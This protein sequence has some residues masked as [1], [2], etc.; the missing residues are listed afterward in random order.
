MD[1]VLAIAFCI[2]MEGLFTGAE[3][4][5]ISADRHKLTERARSGKR[6]ARI[7]LDLLSRPDRTLATTLTGTDLFVVLS[8]VLT[9]S[10]LLPRVGAHAE[11]TTVAIISPL[12]ILFG[13]IVPKTFARPRADVLAEGAAR[14]VRA[15]QIFLYPLV[16]VVSFFGRL[17]SKPLG[18]VPPL[19][20]VVSREELRLILQM[21]RAGSDVEAHERVMVR[22]A[23]SF[24]EKKVADIFRPLAQVVALPEGA[25]C[26]EAAL[27]ASR[28][29]YSR[30]PVYRERIDRVVGFL[31]IL[32]AV[33]APPGAP[34]LPLLRKVLFVPEL[35]PIDELMRKFRA[36]RTSFAVAVDEFGGVTGIVTAEDVVEEVVGEIEDE[37]D[38]GMEYYKKIAPDEFLVPGTMEVRRFEEELG[39][40][41]PAGD[42]STVGGMLVS[43]AGR[44]PAAGETFSV[45]GAVFIVARSTE[46]AVKEVRVILSSRGESVEEPVGQPA[47]ERREETE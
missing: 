28:S 39:V 10:Y 17:L 1:I 8:T 21:S 37:Y 24:G 12:V 23:F 27:L 34:I 29:G 33:G 47:A 18:G 41:L 36:E 3:M 45:P 42:Y 26:R 15:A 16:A 13:E 38:R 35:M 11:W 46:R 2:L 5:L 40:S 43:L 9:A 22:R 31:H 30:Y 25:V 44:I 32:D 19:H 14:F 4:V 7:A 20:D 6:G